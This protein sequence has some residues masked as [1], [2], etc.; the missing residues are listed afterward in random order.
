M[1]SR[2][3]FIFIIICFL[4]VGGWFFVQQKQS[5]VD[6]SASVVNNVVQSDFSLE[7]NNVE[8]D[9]EIVA[10]S[11]EMKKGLSGRIDLAEDQGMLFVFGMSGFHS[12][13]MKG[14]L[15]PIDIIW[16]NENKEVVYIKENLQACLE[17]CQL[18]TPDKKS[19]YVLEVKAG[20]VDKIDIKIGDEVIFGAEL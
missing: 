5:Q 16:I 10:T 19:K 18:F 20:I 2:L 8:I 7:I 14:M 15:F 17:N 6:T 9:L 3:F 1:F 12:F 13:W 11:E 4:V